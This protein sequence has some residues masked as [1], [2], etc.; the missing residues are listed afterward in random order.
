[1]E[2]LENKRKSSKNLFGGSDEKKRDISVK[3]EE[4]IK[5][6]NTAERNHVDEIGSMVEEEAAQE[7]V[8]PSWMCES[9]AYEPNIDKDGFITKSTQAILGVLAKLKWNAGKD[10]RFSAS[11][12]LKLCYTLLFILLTACSKNYL[13]SLIMAAGTILALASYPASAMK[14]ILSGTIGAVLFSIFILLPAVFMGNPQILLTI[15]TKVF[16]S[17]TLIGMLSAGTAWNKLTASLRAFHIPDIFI[18]TL[19]ITLKYIAVLGEICMEI[20]TSL[21]LRSIGQN[22]KK[23]KAFSGILGISFLKSREMADEMYAAMCCRGFV[24]EYKTGRKYTFQKQDI[25]YILSMIAV[26]GLFVYLE[27]KK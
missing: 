19:D 8:L 6:G 27:W 16:L 15:G 12:F 26:V 20:L 21:R 2:D 9:E 25:F 11:P 5:T 18:F 13:F 3:T 1:M 14:Q 17:V 10:G 22:K 7:T 4:K 24:G 23:A